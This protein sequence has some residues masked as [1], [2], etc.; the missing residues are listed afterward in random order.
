M[1]I[2][3]KLW[4][5]LRKQYN[6]LDIDVFNN[7]Y[8][9]YKRLN[10]HLKVLKFAEFLERLN[11]PRIEVIFFRFISMSIDLFRWKL[12]D[13]CMLIINGRQFNLYGVTIFCGRQRKW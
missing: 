11:I 9:L 12:Y 6:Y 3:N 13:L 10:F 5:K 7:V 2:N 4:K 8:F 1:N